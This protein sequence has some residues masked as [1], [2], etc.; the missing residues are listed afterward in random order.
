MVEREGE[1]E[2]GSSNYLATSFYVSEESRVILLV[3]AESKRSGD[4]RSHRIVNASDSGNDVRQS[5]TGKCR[6]RSGCLA[7]AD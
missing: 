3:A 7:G 6:P 4:S 1:R 5:V 2:K